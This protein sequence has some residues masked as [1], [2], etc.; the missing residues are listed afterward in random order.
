MTKKIIYCLFLSILL[1]PLIILEMYFITNHKRNVEQHT[2][3]AQGTVIEIRES[4]RSLTIFYSPVVQ[5]TINGKVILSKAPTRK[6]KLGLDIAV[7]DTVLVKYNPNTKT[8]RIVGYD[9]D[10]TAYFFGALFI[11]TVIMIGVVISFVFIFELSSTIIKWTMIFFIVG[12]VILIIMLSISS[13]VFNEQEQKL[14]LIALIAGTVI[15]KYT[16]LKIKRENR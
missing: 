13:L 12:E 9:N 5:Y 11:F 2:E 6:S 3:L 4:R 14:I 8:I 1:I 16:Q 15:Y 7:R 10:Y